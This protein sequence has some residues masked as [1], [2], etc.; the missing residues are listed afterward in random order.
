MSP[1]PVPVE[2]LQAAIRE[3]KSEAMNDNEQKEQRVVV[4]DLKMPF[5][6]MVVFLIK[7]ALASIP[8]L[9]IVWGVMMLLMMLFMAL[10]GGI[11]GVNDLFH[12]PPQ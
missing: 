7:L 4:T 5:G 11:W 9:L 6:S 1:G 12:Q 10:F 3:A 2:L 8:A